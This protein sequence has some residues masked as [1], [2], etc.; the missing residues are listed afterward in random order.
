MASHTPRLAICFLVAVGCRSLSHVAT[1][2]PMVQRD[3]PTDA[4]VAH[5]VGAAMEAR[6]DLVGAREQYRRALRLD[7]DAATVEVA[8]ARVS[9]PPS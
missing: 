4:L 7:P 5:L 2:P 8:L 1:P 9:S 6:G 3:P